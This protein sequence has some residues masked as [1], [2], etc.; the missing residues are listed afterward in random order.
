MTDAARAAAEAL[1]QAV[2]EAAVH[3]YDQA[4]RG[5]TAT[6]QSLGEIADAHDALYAAIG[7]YRATL[8]P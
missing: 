3:Y 4:Q 1:A 6:A 2:L 5:D 8:S 7:R